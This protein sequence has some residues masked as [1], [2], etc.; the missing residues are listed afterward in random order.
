MKF[1]VWLFSK[2]SVMSR[3]LC[4]A[5]KNDAAKNIA[6]LLSR[7]QCQRTE[8]HSKFNKIY[9]F[10]CQFRGQLAHFVMTSVSGHLETLE[11]TGPYREWRLGAISTLFEAPI[12]RMIN[13]NMLPIGQTLK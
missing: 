8:G 1:A 3:I 13:P 2:K 7:G 6:N 12:T 5:E 11:F 4:V 10:D 9:R